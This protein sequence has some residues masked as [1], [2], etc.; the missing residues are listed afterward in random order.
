MQAHDCATYYGEDDDIVKASENALEIGEV[1]FVDGFV[2]IDPETGEK[3]VGVAV[4]RVEGDGYEVIVQKRL[5][6]HYSAQAAEL[7][8]LIEALYTAKGCAV[9][10]YSDSAY[11]TTAVQTRLSR[12]RRRA[13][14]RADGSTVQHA[15]L[16]NDLIEALA[17][18]SVVALVKCKAH[19]NNTDVISLG[20]AAADAS[21]KE[22]APVN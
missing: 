7:V 15:Q 21:V 19:T 17:E 9:T 20:N 2:S 3:H 5:P 16:L 11:V 14:R 1:Y 8:A 18:P 4:V 10:I 22:A 13:F 12:W 6:S